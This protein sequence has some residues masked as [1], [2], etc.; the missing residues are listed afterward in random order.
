MGRKMIG[1]YATWLA[2]T[3]GPREMPNILG[4]FFFASLALALALWT[5]LPAFH[6]L[7]QGVPSQGSFQWQAKDGRTVS[8]P[9]EPLAGVD[10]VV[11]V[12]SVV[13]LLSGLAFCVGWL[14]RFSE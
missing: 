6:A 1:R 5:G 11:I 10:A 9:I 3:S 8:T 7:R 12:A 14:D 2:M 4:V 13:L